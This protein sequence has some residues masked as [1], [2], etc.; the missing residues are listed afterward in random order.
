MRYLKL[1]VAIAAAL[2]ALTVVAQTAA[3]AASKA[4]AATGSLKICKVAAPP[5]AGQ[6]FPFQVATWSGADYNLLSLTAGPAPGG[7]ATVGPLTVGTILLVEEASTP[8]V[9]YPG[10]T[11]SFSL[12]S[13]TFAGSNTGMDLVAVTVA[14][15][16]TT[17][18]V[19]DT[20]TPPP[21]TGTLELCKTAADKYV[22]GSFTFDLTGPDS[23]SQTV[24][25]PTGQ[26]NDYPVPS[27]AIGI[28][29]PPEF[30]Y[31]LSS[32]SAIPSS[33][34]LSSDLD[35]QS[36]SVDVQPG[37][38]TT[39]FFTNSTL[40]G[41]VKV[42]KTLARSADDVLAG[43]TF[44]YSLT[45]TFNGVSIP[46]PGVSVVAQ[47]YPTQTCAFAEKGN[48]M[49]ALPLGTLVTATETGLPA[50][51]HIQSVGTSVSPSNLNA[52]STSS[53]TQSLYVGNLPAPNNVGSFGAGSVTQANFTNEAYGTVEVCKT[54]SSIAMGT[55]FQFT[56][57]GASIPPVEVGYCSNGVLLPVGTTTITEGS[58][59]HITL[60]SV[61]AST[62]AVSQ[63]GN[64]V[65]VTVPYDSD[66]IVT[67]NNEIN[68][69]TL[70]ICKA[71]TSS[72]AGL[73]GQTFTLGYSYT[74]DGETTTGSD[75]L[76]PGQC[77]LPIYNVPV[78]N[79]NLT[80]V[81]VSI[82]EQTTSI[83]NIGLFSVGVVGTDTVVS[84]PAPPTHLLSV[85][86]G[87]TAATEVLN[88]L[89]GVTTVTFVNGI[90][91]PVAG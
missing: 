19:T 51:G 22:S 66:N 68:S 63:S 89:E 54:S 43:Q 14:A 77:A 6:S 48:K 36:A 78:L 15:G 12:S 87:G 27:G 64:S 59:S 53:T 5:L 11:P 49:I 21:A 10:V 88:S 17:L 25:V 50:D 32:V 56:V 33:A 82:T 39:A 9:A 41:Y 46:V 29:E 58:Q 23:F 26:C 13:G 60:T 1:L 81:T 20:P 45:A 35:T 55:P 83:A 28:T 74:V 75:P 79:S 37:S 8:G 90:D 76:M 73:Q 85:S 24:S 30:P 7:C 16:T 18:T 67:F 65:T 40:T 84:S 47:D 69:G 57:A 44:T 38:T 42:C 61:T 3:T 91:I 86:Q 71:Q 80:P 52:G 4:A 72:D 70:K 62:G 2:L 34:L 31:A